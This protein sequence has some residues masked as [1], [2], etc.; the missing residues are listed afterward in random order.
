MYL[1]VQKASSQHSLAL[2]PC[3]PNSLLLTAFP[4]W[5]I[6]HRL[7]HLSPRSLPS[8]P[9]LVPERPQSGQ[10]ALVKGQAF[11]TACWLP[12]HTACQTRV[13]NL[14]TSSGSTVLQLCPPKGLAP[15]PELERSWHRQEKQPSPHCGEKA[16]MAHALLGFI[17]ATAHPQR[18]HGEIKRADCESKGVTT[19]S[20]FNLISLSPAPHAH[21][22]ILP[23]P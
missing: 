19:F 3:R 5:F 12:P 13:S 8:P 16:F 9:P 22:L 6:R 1:C 2:Q 4:A 7:L 11:I 20:H 21:Y 17:P 23:A 10:G 14:L 18:S 15:Q